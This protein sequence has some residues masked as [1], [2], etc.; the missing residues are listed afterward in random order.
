MSLAE[1]WLRGKQIGKFP[2]FLDGFREFPAHSNSFHLIP[3]VVSEVI[4]SIG[5]ENLEIGLVAN[6]DV[7]C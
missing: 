2:R 6:L 5:V 1:E 3:S 7:D 4:R